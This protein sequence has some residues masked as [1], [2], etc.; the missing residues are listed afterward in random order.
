MLRGGSWLYSPRNCRSA[1][2]YSNYGVVR[3]T[4]DND[5]GFRVV[6]VVG[7]T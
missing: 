3:G 2:R 5:I 6:C 4:F 7:R 1:S